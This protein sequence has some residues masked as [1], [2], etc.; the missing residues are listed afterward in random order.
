MDFRQVPLALALALAIA[1]VGS[2]CAGDGQ[3][4]PEAA[5][6]AAGAPAVQSDPHGSGDPHA[7]DDHGQHA[8]AGMD[9]PVADGHTPWMPDAPLLEGMSRIRAAIAGLEGGPGP[10]TVA[11]R[12][13]EVD[14]A[15]EY[16]FANCRLDPEPDVALHAILARLMA[17]TRA[18]QADPAD[19]AP[20]AGMHAAIANYEALFD[21]P[22]G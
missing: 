18:L 21:D 19:L 13:A 8:L 12:A 6:G 3:L 22:P 2:G 1:A 7:Q 16:M 15:I 9:F 11:T 5:T 20:V 4:P 17:A 10:A 14:A